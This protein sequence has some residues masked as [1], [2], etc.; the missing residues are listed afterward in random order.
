MASN[1]KQF[2]D[3]LIKT[4]LLI[5]QPKLIDCLAGINKYGDDDNERT[6]LLGLFFKYKLDSDKLAPE[7]KKKLIKTI[8]EL[9]TE[10]YYY[11]KETPTKDMMKWF[12]Y[13][14]I[15]AGF[16][17]IV[18]GIIQMINGNFT[19]G[20]N[21]RYLQPVIRGGGYKIIIGLLLCI[22]GLIRLQFELQKKKL[23]NEL[24]VPAGSPA[25]DPA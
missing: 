1:L 11:L 23:L 12:T 18:A 2:I 4:P 13:V 15:I 14:L 9:N 24:H 7:E 10:S 5:S 17:G 16:A 21:T 20:I 19:Y 6:Y 3:E 22:G 25:G 8:K